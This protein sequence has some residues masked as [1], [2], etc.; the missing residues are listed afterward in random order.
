MKGIRVTQVSAVDRDSASVISYSFVDDHAWF[1]IDRTTGVISTAA[2]IEC[3][4]EPEVVLALL[5]ADDGGLAS[6]AV[7][8]LTVIDIN[9]SEPQ[10]DS[11][12]YNVSIKESAAIGTCLLKVRPRWLLGLLISREN[13]SPMWEI[14][15]LKIAMPWN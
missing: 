10:F 9:N 14:G 13:G 8:R 4:Q 1:S 11:S 15:K 7:V 6:T 2:E 5:A 3:E 12:F